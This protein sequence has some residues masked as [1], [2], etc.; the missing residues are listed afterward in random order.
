MGTMS[1]RYDVIIIGTGPAGIFSALEL[2][3]QPGLK[4]LMIEKGA[5]IQSRSCP[6]MEGDV[7]CVLCYLCGILW[8]WG[9]AGRQSPIAASGPPLHGTR[10]R[11]HTGAVT[12]S[13]ARSDGGG[14]VA[15]TP[16]R[17]HTAAKRIRTPEPSTLRTRTARPLP[18]PGERVII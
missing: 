7:P 10:R 5:D 11:H 6:I 15:A 9:G 12:R 3:K 18:S 17:G 14:A 2:V 13:D 16:G 8:G 1:E 4:V